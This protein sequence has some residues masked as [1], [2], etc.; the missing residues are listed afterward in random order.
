M[1]YV[2]WPAMPP[3]GEDRCLCRTPDMAS[4]FWC[5]RI[6]YV[7]RSAAILAACVVAPA[8]LGQG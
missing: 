5:I 6:V 1:Y 7:Q 3:S 2:Q 8:A 4:T